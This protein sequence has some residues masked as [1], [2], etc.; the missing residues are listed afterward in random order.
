VKSVGDSTL[1]SADD[2]HKF[3][4]LATLIGLVARCDCTLD[5]IGHVITQNLFFDPP[6]G[7]ANGRDLRDDI[8]AIAILLDH[9]GET[10]NLAFNPAQ[11]VLASL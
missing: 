4:D 10:A 5:T 1:G 6:Q 3:L 11:P 7:C 8:D 9:S 2:R